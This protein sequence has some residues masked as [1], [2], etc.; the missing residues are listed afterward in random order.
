MGSVV[1]GY[2]LEVEMLKSTHLKTSGAYRMPKK[3]PEGSDGLHDKGIFGQQIKVLFY[4]NA[5][6]LDIWRRQ[7]GILWAT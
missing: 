6:H 1:L 5:K 3:I 7:F 4:M 2:L